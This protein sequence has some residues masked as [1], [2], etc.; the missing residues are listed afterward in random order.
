MEYYQSIFK[1][2]L[3]HKVEKAQMQYCMKNAR[4]KKV[5]AC[6]SIYIQFVCLCSITCNSWRPYGL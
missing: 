2:S 4:H 1:K 6:D 3:Q 5:L